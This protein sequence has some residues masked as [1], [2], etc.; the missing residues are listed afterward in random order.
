MLTNVLYLNLR[1]ITLAPWLSAT[2]KVEFLS[3]WKEAILKEYLQYK[4]VTDFDLS[5]SS[6]IIQMFLPYL[7]AMH[8]VFFDKQVLHLCIRPF[9][10]L[11]RRY[12]APCFPPTQ[13]LRCL[14][15]DIFLH[16]S[17]HECRVCQSSCVPKNFFGWGSTNS[18]ED[19]ENGDLGAVA[20]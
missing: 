20:P 1:I 6:V 7:E 10:V 13:P 19:R 2:Y 16:F 18:V 3:C 5:C 9:P 14:C 12:Q 8:K 11:F 4:H 15:Q 17:C